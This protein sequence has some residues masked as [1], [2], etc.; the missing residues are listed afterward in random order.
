MK[1]PKRGHGEGSISERKS[2][3]DWRGEIMLGTRADGSPDRR[4]VYGPTRRAVQNKLHELRQQHADGILPDAVKGRETFGAFLAS[5]LESITGTMEPASFER[6]QQNVGRHIIPHLG[7]MKLQDVRP[8]HL[9]SLFA[10]LRKELPAPKL[11]S[12]EA[13]RVKHTAKY[14]TSTLRPLAARSIKYA[15]TTLRLALDSAVRWGTIPRNVA[16]VID[17]PKV[18]RPEI[19][20]LAPRDIAAFLDATAEAGDRLAPLYTVAVMS[21]C[22]LGGMP[23]KIL[24]S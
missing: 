19:I 9:V 8:D 14:R 4:Y 21:G 2:R 15:F 23:C 17:A 22:R 24:E 5:W 10:T 20:S 12:D 1:R 11:A 7:R 6:H 16:R 18:S 13:P 3:S